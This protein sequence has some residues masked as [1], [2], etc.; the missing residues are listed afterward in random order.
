MLS[1]YE[2]LVAVA[3]ALATA[4]VPYVVVGGIAFSLH[5]EIRATEDLD[6]LIAEE[7]WEKVQAVLLP[8][9]YEQLAGA[10]DFP[11]I[12]IRRLTRIKGADVLVIDFLLADDRTRH[13]L[14]GPVLI[15]FRGEL[16]P[17]APV[18]VLIDLKRRR[19]SPKDVS[20]IRGLEAKLNEELGQE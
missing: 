14:Q 16:L 9:G 8:L 19:M 2:E 11:E 5:V 18:E 7:N 4:Q 3:R 6:L 1:L 17:L 15:P 13:A 12:R 20:D 10:M